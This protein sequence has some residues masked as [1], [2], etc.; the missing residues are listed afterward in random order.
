MS[1]RYDVIIVGGGHAGCE[2]AAASARMVLVLER[3]QGWKAKEKGLRPWISVRNRFES[4]KKG[5]V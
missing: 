5:R 2:A 3:S 1:N 4:K